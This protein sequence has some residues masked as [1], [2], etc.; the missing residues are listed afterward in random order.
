MVETS[1]TDVSSASRRPGVPTYVGVQYLRALA[2]IA[3]VVFHAAERYGVDFSQ[4]AR[5]VDVFF[6]I[7]GFI[8]WTVTTGRPATPAGFLLDRVRRIVPLYW[9]A[10]FV[11]IGATLLGVA[12]TGQNDLSLGSVLKSLLFIPYVGAGAVHAWPILGPGWTL[13]F[14][15]FFYGVFALFLFAPAR[16]R[17]LGLTATFSGLILLGVLLDPSAPVLKT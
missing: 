12:P 3:V 5:G 15:M 11:L 8:M 4:G 7:S 2:A 14:E 1:P 13:N 10:T 17:L 9:V 6:V 16:L